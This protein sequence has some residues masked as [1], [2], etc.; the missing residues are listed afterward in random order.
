MSV[1]LLTE[2]EVARVLRCSPQKVRKLRHDCLL[3]FIPS[4]PVMIDERDL[5][6]YLDSVKVPARAAEGAAAADAAA[7]SAA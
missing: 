5:E 6:A 4:R 1:K 2:T 7:Q 3:A